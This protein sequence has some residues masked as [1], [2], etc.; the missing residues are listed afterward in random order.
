MTNDIKLNLEAQ[1]AIDDLVKEERALAPDQLKIPEIIPGCE[2]ISLDPHN[3]GLATFPRYI[4]VTVNEFHELVRWNGSPVLSVG[5][6]C[7]V[8][9]Q[10]GG[11]TYQVSGSSGAA[12][13]E[14]PT[15]VYRYIWVYDI[16]EGQLVS[17]TTIAGALAYPALASGDYVLIPPGAYDESITL[18]DGVIVSEMIP[19]TVI[20]HSTSADT[21]VTCAD[22]GY[23]QVK[24][25]RCTG[26]S[27]VSPIAVNAAFLGAGETSEIHAEL[28]K[29]ECTNATGGEDVFGIAGGG[30]GTVHVFADY[31][32]ADITENG[33]GNSCY[34]VAAMGD[35]FYIFADSR[36]NN[37]SDGT[38]ATTAN[39]FATSGI[40]YWRGHLFLTSDDG[41]EAYNVYMTIGSTA[42]VWHWG[43]GTIAITGVGATCGSLVQFGG[44]FY[45]FGN[46][47]ATAETGA[48]GAI[49]SG[50]TTNLRG[51]FY[52]ETTGNTGA[53]EAI[54]ADSSGGA[55]TLCGNA[56]SVGIAGTIYGA[57]CTGAGSFNFFNGYASGATFDLIR[58]AGTMRV[59]MVD[60]DTYSGTITQYYPMVDDAWIG[61]AG[62]A[63]ARLVFDTTP[64]PDDVRL[65]DATLTL[66]NTGLHLLDTDASH[67]LIIAPGSDITADRTLT[68]T[69]GDADR[70]LTLS[71]NLTIGATTSITGGG[72]IALGG[73]T[74]T[75][76]ATGTVFIASGI[77]GGQTGYGGTAA[78]DDL[79][80]EGTSHATKTTSYVLLQPNGGNVGIGDI[81]P[82][83]KL[84]IVGSVAAT[85]VLRLE[86]A[87]SQSGDYL[88]V[89]AAGGTTGALLKINSDGNLE[90]SSGTDGSPKVSECLDITGYSS[91]LR[92]TL[93]RP[94]WQNNTNGGGGLSLS[95]FMEPTGNVALLY[96]QINTPQLRNSASDVTTFKGVFFRADTGADYSGAVAT[97]R[98]VEISSGSFAGSSPATLVGLYIDSQTGGTV[99]NYAVYSMAG[100]WHIGDKMEF[101]Q[102]DGNEAIDSLAD[103]YMDYL[104]TTLHRFNNPLTIAN[105]KTGATQAAAGAAAN[106]LWATVGHASLPD[107]V[108][109]IGV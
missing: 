81:T 52:A 47:F 5:D 95:P 70:A 43:D 62:G 26:G 3:V 64:V 1:Q 21:C 36:V 60:F 98:H 92:A 88:Q 94:R 30:S 86:G 13:T 83:A 38:Q 108:V 77:A 34:A 80:L 55:L 4:T 89:D 12:G 100:V 61:I 18:V 40:C 75:V 25:I 41:M 39:L 93:I 53:E 7:T 99:S 79:T 103:G 32:D 105:I 23:I 48:Y 24:E 84:D 16:S 6:I 22:G 33:G 58:V 46:G 76:P 85:P 78:N 35:T 109:M 71:G 9:K 54:G 11:N 101:T 106:E 8:V 90:I 59:S 74:L 51:H 69:T 72:T 87:A 28:I 82:D 14:S 96:G 44:T 57:R 29:A 91:A 67:D 45:R 31:I 15:D 2:V 17:Y 56:V 102:T 50:G 19:G 65:Y 27:G 63:G 10:R 97:I 73:F 104:A 37:D 20:L 49:S 107:Y 68:I 42:T 66:P